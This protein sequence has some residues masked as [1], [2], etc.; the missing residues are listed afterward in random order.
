MLMPKPLVV[1]VVALCAGACS[2]FAPK[3]ERPTLTLTGIQM[4]GGNM[5]QQNFLVK[6]RIQNPNDRVLPVRAVH[7]ELHVGGQE[8][9]SGVTNRAFVVPAFGSSEFDMTITANVAMTLLKLANKINKH[10]DSLDYDLTGAA[11]IDLPFLRDLPF[12]QNGSFSLKA[13]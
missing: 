13:P 11:S 1:L 6:L 3:Y 10:A 4:L 12:H 9:A 5:L 8:V 7:A 2:L